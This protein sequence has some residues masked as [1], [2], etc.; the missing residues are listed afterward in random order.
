MVTMNILRKIKLD[1]MW[2][3]GILVISL[4]MIILFL[5]PLMKY[6]AGSASFEVESVSL[7]PIVLD[8]TN[9]QPTK[10]PIL[11]VFYPVNNKEAALAFGKELARKLEGLNEFSSVEVIYYLGNAERDRRIMAHEN[12]KK[13]DL[14]RIK[15]DT[16]VSQNRLKIN[17]TPLATYPRYGVYL[18]ATTEMPRCDGSYLSGKSL[19]L[20]ADPSS[21]SGH[22]YAKRCINKNI[23]ENDWP[24]FVS[25]FPSHEYLLKALLKGEVDMISSYWDEDLH[26]KYPKWKATKIG[27]VPEGR[28]PAWF[29]E[30]ANHQEAVV[31]AITE[32]LVSH[33]KTMKKQ[34]WQDIELLYRCNHSHE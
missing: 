15:P 26:I 7:S 10:H 18:I 4:L 24:H 27:D 29:F 19:G 34:Y 23:N 32:A 12:N 30:R 3:R 31:C 22:S 28:R 5:H 17:Y 11:R 6:L 1:L 20:R 2:N 25:E 9:T 21:E 13:F 8:I 14:L 33:A 16:L